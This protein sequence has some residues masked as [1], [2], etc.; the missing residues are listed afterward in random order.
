[1]TT[2]VSIAR[3]LLTVTLLSGPWGWSSLRADNPQEGKKGTVIGVV[4]DKGTNFIEVKADGEEKARRYVPDWVGGLPSQGGGFDKDMI[5]AI[6]K[7]PLGARV[8]LDWKFEERPR[9]VK[10]EVLQAPKDNK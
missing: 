8:K 10:L 5:A 7:V 1:M 6:A 2:P 4:T 3:L 9:V